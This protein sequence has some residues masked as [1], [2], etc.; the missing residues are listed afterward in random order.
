MGDTTVEFVENW[1]AANLRSNGTAPRDEVSAARLAVRCWEDAATHHITPLQI[2]N[3]FGD[4]LTFI[5]NASETKNE[6][7]LALLAQQTRK[8]KMAL[9][10]MM[11]NR[12][13]G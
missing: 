12:R 8:P 9:T 2:D 10:G 5:Q 13:A 7:R 1:L 4:L 3:K 11:E 6:E